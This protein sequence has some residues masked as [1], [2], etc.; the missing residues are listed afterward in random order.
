MIDKWERTRPWHASS[1]MLAL[2]SATALFTVTALTAASAEPNAVP[3]NLSAVLKAGAHQEFAAPTARG[4]FR[5]VYS[6]SAQSLRFRLTFSGLSGPVRR[7]ELHIGKITHAGLTGRYPVCDGHSV[8]CLAGKW[9]TIEQVFPDLFVE[10]ARR[11]GY[12]DLHT[13]KNAGGE[14]AGKLR[15]GK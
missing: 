4:T 2:V 5:A 15:V 11:G 9:I 6:P 10:L 8:L 13:L 12:I 3:T 1:A 14:A 7:A